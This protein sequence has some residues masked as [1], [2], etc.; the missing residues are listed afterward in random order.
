MLAAEVILDSSVVSYHMM[1]AGC[2]VVV[3]GCIHHVVV[4]TR[5]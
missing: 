3:E 5:Q 2:V 1:S 4:K